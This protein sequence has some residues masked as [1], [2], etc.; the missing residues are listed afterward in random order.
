MQVSLGSTTTATASNPLNAS[1]LGSGTITLTS[2]VINATGGALTFNNFLAI[3]NNAV[4]GFG[5]TNLTFNPS[6]A[7]PVA[8]P[9]STTLLLNSNVTFTG[10]FS[11]AA[12]AS[13]TL[14][15][16]PLVSE[17]T[18]F[19]PTGTLTLTGPTSVTQNLTI[20]ISGGTLD[21]TGTG[22]LVTT[23]T[24]AVTIN[25][26]GGLTLDNTSTNQI[27][28]T[29][30][31]QTNRLLSTG[32]QT[33]TFNGGTL[34]FNG[35]TATNATTTQTL[36]NVTFSSGSST[37]VSNQG[38]GPAALALGSYTRTPSATVTFQAG[39]TGNQTF[40][41]NSNTISFSSGYTPSNGI[42][43]GAYVNDASTLNAGAVTSTFKLATN[44][45][46]NVVAQTTYQVLNLNGGNAATDNVLVTSSQVLTSTYLAANLNGTTN[47]IGTIN[48]LLLVG[49]GISISGNG[50]TV[51]NGVA[52]TLG[53][54]TFS[55]GNSLAAS[56]PLLAGANAEILY[57]NSGDTLTLNA[58]IYTTG[59]LTI[60]GAG[61]LSL[62]NANVSTGVATTTV[63]GAGN[64]SYTAATT[65]VAF[66]NPGTGGTTAQGYAVITA[67]NVSSIV[68][69]NPGSGYVT[70][71]TV[72]ISST[73]GGS[74]NTATATINTNTT[75]F[76]G[77]IVLD[78]GQAANSG[79]LSLGG[80]N[81]IPGTSGTLTLNNGTLSTST[82]ILIPNA[83]TLG[84][85]IADVTF[86]GSGSFTFNGA[87]T[88]SAS[89]VATLT[90]NGTTTI[91][92]AI[93]GAVAATLIKQGT[94][95][96]ALAGTN[97]YTGNTIVGAGMVIAQNSSAVVPAR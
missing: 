20:T 52:S 26:G 83:V 69:T 51:N 56:T 61:T 88:V 40:T 27:P 79:T 70:V 49:D 54:A 59:G 7:A 16:V 15:G 31:S 66:S 86:A 46:S 74:G 97:T 58:P 68:I 55:V 50:L 28:S 13:L 1:S 34:T 82:A 35:S 41:T 44:S 36:G 64:G 94:G 6:L 3:S 45:G 21:L 8:L 48:S 85:Q 29:G 38:S 92:G 22:T 4:V 23:G 33:L 9:A 32:A 37:I 60:A 62:P 80:N 14:S 96:L 43:V 18:T 5:G 72:T 19:N 57:T 75:S 25:Q 95:T 71:P 63:A 67:G 93:G 89:T 81:S 24:S 17:A 91:N 53:T 65:T 47:T 90:T 42:V 77:G 78:G 2:G 11:T 73:S 30:A 84:S 76:T 87:V 39:A 10:I 12:A